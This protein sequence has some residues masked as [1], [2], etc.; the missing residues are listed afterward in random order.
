MKSCKT[1]KNNKSCQIKTVLR[2][3]TKINNG[4]RLHCSAYKNAYRETVDKVFDVSR[5]G[6]GHWYQ[7]EYDKPEDS[8]LCVVEYAYDEEFSETVYDYGIR[9]F[10]DTD[11]CI[12]NWNDVRRWK[13]LHE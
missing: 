2:R 7:F 6:L 5:G 10:E 3:V 1:C 4:E 8:S 13:Y 11:R 12:N 9:L